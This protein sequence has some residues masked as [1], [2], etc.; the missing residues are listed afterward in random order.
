MTTSFTP[1]ERFDR[2]FLLK[3][4]SELRTKAGKPYLALTLGTSSGEWEG[5][6]WEMEMKSLPG[7]VEGDTVQASG[8]AELYQER[9]QLNIEHITPVSG[10]L[11]PRELYPS[12]AAGEGELRKGFQEAVDGIADPH[13][14]ALMGTMLEDMVVS[15]G[16]FISPA[17]VAM[18][19]ARIG[20]LA[21]HSL[22]VHRL[23]L[24]AADN[25]PWLDRDILSVGALLH[26]VGKVLEY[27]VAGDFRYTLEGKLLGHIVQGVSLVQG[28]ISRLE[29]FPERL[30]LEVLHIVLSHHGQLEHGSP[31]TPATPEAL[32]VHFADDLDAKLDM[33]G[34]AARESGNTEAFVRGLRRS[35]LFRGEETEDGQGVP[36]EEPE[37][38]GQAAGTGTREPANASPD[39]EATEGREASVRRRGEEGRIKKKSGQEELF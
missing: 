2:V 26:D 35:F 31:R 32:V 9:L 19:H 21:E 13:L 38:A 36:P 5:R 6:V 27:E 11:D 37:Q 16:F 34:S 3:G 20:G 12:S 8:T 10:R 23:A 24:A 14:K 39:V 18:H 30:A 4:I 33:V 25:A 1:N 22:G 15:D 17:A 28:W 29:G 7:L